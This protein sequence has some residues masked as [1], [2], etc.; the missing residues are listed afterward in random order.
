MAKSKPLLYNIYQDLVTAAK[1]IGE[2][3]F[4]DRPKSGDKDLAKFVVVNVPTTIHNRVKGNLGVMAGCFGLYS[5]FC[6]AKT[7]ATLNIGAQSDMVQS[8]LDLFP[9][10]G[11]HISAVEPTVLMRGEDGYGYQVTQISFK[12]RTKFNI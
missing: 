2:G 9:I 4:L 10:N 6:K 7:N 8:I 11:E 1:G 12:I 3:V 5:V